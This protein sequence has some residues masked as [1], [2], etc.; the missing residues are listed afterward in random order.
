MHGIHGAG[1]L[2]PPVAAWHAKCSWK[3]TAVKTP[4]G[5]HA[6]L[7][8]Q[9]CHA[10]IELATTSAGAAPCRLWEWFSVGRWGLKGYNFK[11][12]RFDGETWPQEVG[13]HNALATL[14]TGSMSALPWL[15]VEVSTSIRHTC[16]CQQCLFNRHSGCE[17]CELRLN[18]FNCVSPR[19]Y[20][21]AR[22]LQQHIDSTASLL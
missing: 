9:L 19:L 2:Q 22:S 13:K 1:A 16:T 3:L 14:A 21:I 11:E 20:D 15:L 5:T 18:T 8:G 7:A 10:G 4:I 6:Q 17:L 12:Q